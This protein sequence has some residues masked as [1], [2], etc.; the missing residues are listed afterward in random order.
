[1]M[2]MQVAIINGQRWASSRSLDPVT[3]GAHSQQA[4][5]IIG[6]CRRQF[7]RYIL[8][9]SMLVPTRK[10]GA[11]QQFFGAHNVDN[12]IQYAWVVNMGVKPQLF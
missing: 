4:L 3:L 6:H 10:I 9:H 1:M 11:E 12:P 5:S 7:R 8:C 2:P